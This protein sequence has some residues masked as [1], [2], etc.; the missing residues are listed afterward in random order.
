MN[1]FTEA[2]INTNGENNPILASK[3]TYR[4]FQVSPYFNFIKVK[5][6]FN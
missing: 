4:S 3:H 5:F 2:T 1:K 6:M